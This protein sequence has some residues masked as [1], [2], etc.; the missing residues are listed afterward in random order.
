MITDDS[1]DDFSCMD[2]N[3]YR[4]FLVFVFPIHYSLGLFKH[5]YRHFQ[6]SLHAIFVRVAVIELFLPG[7]YAGGT[8]VSHAYRLN[9]L[10]CIIMAQLVE[11][12]EKLV[13]QMNHILAFFFHDCVEVADVAEKHRYIILSLLEIVVAVFDVLV[14][15]LRNK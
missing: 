10:D 3:L 8:H 5:R 4:Q 6:Q 7:R 11:L 2:T 1:N 13:H 15:E 9:L 14:D 12:S